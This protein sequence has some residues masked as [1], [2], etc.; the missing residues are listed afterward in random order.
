[1]QALKQ[2]PPR[3]G[4]EPVYNS[5]F[6]GRAPQYRDLPP[7]WGPAPHPYT[8]AAHDGPTP[9]ARTR[10]NEQKARPSPPGDKLT[11]HTA[12]ARLASTLASFVL[13]IVLARVMVPAEFAGVA[14]AWAWLA[15][16]MS[17]A[18][19]SMP[20][21]MVRVVPAELAAGR[22]DLARGALR[23]ARLAALAVAL[24]LACAAWAVPWLHPAALGPQALALAPLV[25]ALLLPSVL[26]TLL[27]GE[28]QAIKRV[29]GAEV[30]INLLRPLLVLAALG[31]A[32]QF[33]WWPL[34]AR[35]VLLLYLAATLLIVPLAWAHAR[36]GWPQALR[37]ARPAFAVRPW[38]QL[39]ASY[40]AVTWASVLGERVDLLLLGLTAP[41]DQVAVYA[42]AQRFAQ[43][44][45][46]VL[47]AVPAVLA[48]RLVER[49]ADVHAGRVEVVQSMVRDNAR[50]G[51]KVT[52]L[53]C[54]GLCGVA[55]V[56][57]LLFGKVYAD[58]R[59]P[60]L[61]LAGGL[62]LG[63]LT[64]PGAVVVTLCDAPRL[65][66]AG[67]LAGVVVNA[68][69]NLLLVPYWGPIG[70]AVATASGMVVVGLLCWY[71]AWR[72]LGL[73]T[74]VIGRRRAMEAAA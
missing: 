20:L 10:V 32:W 18:S 14:L 48:P 15:L 64:G 52:G 66:L 62:L 45:S 29:L 19:L 13:F 35:P 9:A 49:L 56:L 2:A 22:A 30:L 8:E 60:T 39:A 74:S 24:V 12:A 4:F 11:W 25:A 72:H 61:V 65:A 59:W 44:T 53:A 41:P 67:V 1:M 3:P 27:T 33:G 58:A 34:Q 51:F 71:W 43:A 36:S 28:L 16:L 42:V 70:A 69:L 23:F 6:E 40:L 38:W 47:T 26:L 5:G 68:T 46:T 17:V 7:S 57:P 54:L 21:V 55:L 73:D 31:L 50:T 63:S 37:S